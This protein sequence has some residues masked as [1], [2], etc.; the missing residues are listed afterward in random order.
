MKGNSSRLER[1]PRVLVVTAKREKNKLREYA[2]KVHDVKYAGDKGQL[3]LS[4]RDTWRLKHLASIEVLPLSRSGQQNQVESKKR[5]DILQEEV[6]QIT[7]IF[8]EARQG[9]KSVGKG[10]MSSSGPQV[11]I[12][13]LLYIE[14]ND[15]A[16]RDALQSLAHVA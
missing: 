9:L 4:I 6:H 15:C 11:F 12:F 1:K 8:E 5:A 14:R 2:F 7:M 16:S 10:I 13:I 3:A